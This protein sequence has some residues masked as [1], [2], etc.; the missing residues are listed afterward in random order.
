M[1]Q[2]RDIR[3]RIKSI[4]KTQQVTRAMKMVAAAKLRKAQEAIIHARPYANRLKQL[5]EYLLISNEL[6]EL[7]LL[8]KRKGDHLLLV[9]I[10]GVRGLCGG[11]NSNVFKEVERIRSA[12]SG[13]LELI[14]IGKKGI[15]FFTKRNYSIVQSFP[16]SRTSQPN[17]ARSIAQVLIDRFI[18]LSVDQVAITYTEF[19]SALSQKV[20]TENLIPMTFAI[21]RQS[22][23]RTDYLYHP[24]SIEILKQ[25]LP[26]FIHSEV[27]R[28]V[29]ESNASELGA[30]MTAMDMATRNSD[31]MI[32]RLTLQYNRA[33]QAAITKELIEVVSG[34]DALIE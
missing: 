12:H 33:R 27:F 19:K 6:P 2:L 9:V 10:A 1:A 17:L 22:Y 11:F 16:T 20:V 18:D 29:L 25:I 28:A 7:P 31:D 24:E 30:R 3:R 5:I 32:S 13:S 26:R 34:A 21:D 23:Q 15:D 14:S 4:K 8:E